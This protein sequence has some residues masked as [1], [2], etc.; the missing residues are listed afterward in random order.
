[1]I[2]AHC[3]IQDFSGAAR[4]LF[5]DMAEA[6]LG[7]LIIFYHSHYY[8]GLC[9]NGCSY[10]AFKLLI[11]R[12]RKGQPVQL[13]ATRSDYATVV[14]GFC[15]EMKME[16]AEK[17][18]EAMEASGHL[19]DLS[20]YADMIHAYSKL[21]RMERA[22]SLFEEAR[23][24][25]IPLN[26]VHFTVLMSGYGRK[27]D[28]ENALGIFYDMKKSGFEPDF[29]AYSIVIH[30][31]CWAGM[32]SKAEELAREMVSSGAGTFDMIISRIIEGLYRC[33]KGEGAEIL[34]D[35][36]KAQK[37]KAGLYI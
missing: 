31:C 26:A 7:D 20:C 18:K 25:K 22:A 29:V 37:I 36:R 34:V 35:Q 21:G 1:M 9:S 6:G 19:A 14:R 33:G 16:A 17:V 32:V 13:F 24:K 4:V 12:H 2:A 5:K 27:E 30:G 23:R 10:L 3:K 11:G 28:V 15:A 8:E